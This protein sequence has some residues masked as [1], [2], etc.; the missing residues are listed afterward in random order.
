MRVSAHQRSETI[1]VQVRGELVHDVERLSESRIGG[2]VDAVPIGAP[3][4][5]TIGVITTE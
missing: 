4:P 5:F 1:L 2:L 3:A